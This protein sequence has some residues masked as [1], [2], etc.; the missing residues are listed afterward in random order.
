[1]IQ[2]DSELHDLEIPFSMWVFGFFTASHK[3]RLL[4][5][6]SFGCCQCCLYNETHNIELGAGVFS[7]LD[8]AIDID[9]VGSRIPRKF[10]LCFI[11]DMH[12]IMIDQFR[13]NHY[14][15]RLS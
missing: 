8:R 13:T 7:V 5:F 14:G 3:L 2:A 12:K 9:S 10:M 4:M 6:G 15:L 11:L 1:M